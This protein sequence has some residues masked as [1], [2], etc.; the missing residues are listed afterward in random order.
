M[1]YLDSEILGLWYVFLSIGGIVVLFD[2]GFNPT[3]A[4]NIAYSWNGTEKLIKT[5]AEIS[6]NSEP[7]IVLLKKVIKTCKYIYLSV[8]ISALI[9][10]LS[11]GTMYVMNVSE[12]LN[13]NI[14]IYSWT[15][16]SLAV[17]LNLYYGYYA[18]FLRGVGAVSE[19]NKVSIISR[20]GQIIIS[21]GL[22]ML[23]FDLLG[24]ALGYL[25]YG[26]FLRVL[27]KYAFFKYRGIGLLISKDSTIVHKSE[28][29]EMFSVMWHNAWRDGLVSVSNYLANQASVIIASMFFSLSVTGIYSISIQLVTAIA[30][31]SGSLYNAFQPSLQ[32]AYVKNNIRESKRLMSIAM[33]VYTLLFLSGVFLLIFIGIPILAKVKSDIN[34]NIPILIGISFYTF[35]LKNHSFYASY[36]SNT[37]RVPYTKAFVLSSLGSVL[38]AVIVLEFSSLGIWGL[39]ISQIVTQMVYNNWK[40]PSVVMSELNTNIFEMVRIGLIGV[41]SSLL[42]HKS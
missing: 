3:F 41:R 40:W 42:M 10:L 12:S 25:A 16:Y 27:S 26:L 19:L 14:V 36:I 29:I 31:I 37:N 18:T 5:N 6:N 17:F 7:N 23:G 20:L 39:I 34:F 24:V 30:T 33:T 2:F 9:I 35:L 28:V 13:S 1:Y 38:L 32:A 4:R 22:L 8:S 21:V 11:F 15:T